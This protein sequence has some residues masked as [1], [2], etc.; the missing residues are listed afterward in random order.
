[1]NEYVVI[2]LVSGELVIARLLHETVEGIHIVNPLQVKMIP[3]MTENDY[4]E[5]AIS[6]KFCQFTEETEFIF[7]TEHM[8]YCKPLN[9]RM[10]PLYDRLIESFNKES[11]EALE[12]STEEDQPTF[13]TKKLH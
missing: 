13:T 5:T 11:S 2:K 10:I 3:V 12:E 4:G 8:V 7:N 1:M 6:S 9:P